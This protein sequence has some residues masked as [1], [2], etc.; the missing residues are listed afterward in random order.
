MASHALLRGIERR[1][2]VRLAWERIDK[3]AR[4]EVQAREDGEALDG[5]ESRESVGGAWM[6][7]VP[8]K[9]QIEFKNVTNALAIPVVAQVATL[10]R[11]GH[12]RWA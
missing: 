11:R 10:P 1:Q 12:H 3:G 9:H 2:R 4:M 8:S 6:D 7:V 5:Y